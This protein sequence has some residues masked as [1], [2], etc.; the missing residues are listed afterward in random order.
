MLRQRYRLAILAPHPVGYHLA[1][2][3]A[4]AAHPRI[5]LMVW[6]CSDMGIS[7]QLDPEFGIPLVWD[8]PAMVLN[9]Y[10]YRFLRNVSPLRAAGRFWSLLNPGIPSI[11]FRERYDALLIPGYAYASYLLGFLAAWV[12]RTP[13]LLRGETHLKAHPPG[14]LQGIGKRL[15]IKTLLKG[16]RACLNIGTPSLLF[17]RA[18]RVPDQR[19]FFSPYSVDNEFFH[20]ESRR[21][22]P[23]RGELK[24]SLGI[25]PELPVILFCGKLIPRKRPGDL[26]TA[27]QRLSHPAALLFV[28]EGPLRGS[29]EKSARSDPRVIF[30]GFIGQRELPKYYAI[31]DLFVLPSERETVAVVVAEAMACGLPLLLSD[32]IPSHVDFVRQGENGFVFPLGD[33]GAL[34]SYLERLLGDETLLR[35]MGQRSFQMIQDW[36]PQASVAGVLKALALVDRR[37]GMGE[38]T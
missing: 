13:V 36:S 21:L 35:R 2:Y 38:E 22:R 30:S 6:Y 20:R 34:S 19:I 9:G 26:L 10:P 14:G 5:D 37:M 28:G 17:Y 29:L 7:G 8:D 31:A 12:S 15:L 25:D 4:L 27:F 16:T 18:Y 24:R 32:A 23:Q 33:I 1:F 11:L 3:R